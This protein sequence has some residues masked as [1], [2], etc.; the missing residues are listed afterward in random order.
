MSFFVK[1]FDRRGARLAASWFVLMS[2]MGAVGTPMACARPGVL[3]EPLSEPLPTIEVSELSRQTD[4]V[5]VFLDRFE[6]DRSNTLIDVSSEFGIGR[7]TVK[8][9]QGEWPEAVT[10]RLHLRGLE[11]F[12]V[13]N[14]TTV[15]EKHQLSVQAYSFNG[16]FFS[17]DDSVDETGYYEVRLPALLFAEGATALEIQWIDFYRR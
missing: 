13:S 7:A 16:R 14:G 2:T 8:L 5:V 11:G 10:V 15:I 9:A 12:T 17:R 4:K 6:A 3:S 1:H